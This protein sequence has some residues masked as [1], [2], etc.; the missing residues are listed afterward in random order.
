MFCKKCGMQLNDHARVCSRCGAPVGAQPGSRAGQPGIRVGQPGQMP[1]A[2]PPDGQG[3]SGG[4]KGGGGLIIG[5][6]IA[7]IV[8]VL[9]AGAGFFL[10]VRNSETTGGS[11][12]TAEETKESEELKETLET[13]DPES[14][15]VETQATLP[16][17][18][19]AETESPGASQEAAASGSLSNSQL[20]QTITKY[21]RE[22]DSTAS[23]QIYAE[24]FTPGT[25][26]TSYAWD[27]NLFYTLE[28]INPNSGTDGLING[29]NIAR[30]MI[31]NASTGNMMEYEIY[32]NP[33][34]GKVNKIVSIEYFQNYLEITDYYYDD[35]G[36]VSFIFV[37]NDINY[38]PSYAIPTKDGQRFYFNSDCMV[39]WRV[40]AGGVQTNYVIGPESAQQNGNASSC[41]Q[42]SSLAADGKSSYDQTEKRMINAAYNTY[43]TALS[44]EGISEITGYVYNDQG[45]PVAGAQVMLVLDGTDEKLYLTESDEAGRYQIMVPSKDSRYRLV[46]SNEDC[47]DATV[48][49]IEISDQILSD[50]QDSVYLVP[51]SDRRYSVNVHMYDALNYAQDGSGM[52]RLS[53]AAIYIRDGVNHRDGGVVAQATANADGVVNVELLP[54]MYTAEVMKQ[55]YDSTYYNFAAMENM[56]AVQINASPRL[57]EGEVR[58]VLTWGYT[59]QDLDSHLFTPYD[60][61]FGDNTYHIWYGNKQDAV[62]NNLDVDDTTGYGPE[63]MTIPVLKNGL[64][65]YYVADF[66]NCSG[67]NPT[68]YEMSASGAM[69]NVYT[70]NGLTATFTVPA[71]VPGVI[72]EV[73]EIRNGSIVPIQR[74]YSNIEDKSWW[75]N[76][77]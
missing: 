53:H 50:Y 63:T 70:S 33:A 51:R 12:A 52:E 47:V 1:P 8:I 35:Y 6:L 28:D 36:K 64:Y 62:G 5:I 32:T 55:G 27:K 20:A 13:E 22:A 74:Y 72:W 24:N 76:D 17:E 16:E 54:G 30:K 77:K 2:V 49:G 43:Q 40:V 48:Y 44:V 23:I 65:K 15:E 18:P 60:N 61:V 11:Q 69:V 42:Y 37:R 19:L 57:A 7:A 25:R 9:A 68:S 59:P 71:N 3:P 38:I 67:N 29:Y 31:R 41:I 73:F 56:D 39:K 34:T 58:I 66:T 14:I 75:H 46:V 4:K 45:I 26:N 10:W 21:N